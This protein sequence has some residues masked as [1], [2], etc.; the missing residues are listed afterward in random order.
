M[1]IDHPALFQRKP[2]NWGSMNLTPFP[3]L[4][5]LLHSS[6]IIW[7]GYMSSSHISSP[8]VAGPQNSNRISGKVNDIAK[9]VQGWEQ[10]E[11]FQ[12]QREL[13][14]TLEVIAL[15]PWDSPCPLSQGSKVL[16]SLYRENHG[17][18]MTHS[19]S[20]GLER[21]QDVQSPLRE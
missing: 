9:Q 15:S 14:E 13:S 21:N 6:W 20:S 19:R 12:G 17:N 16:S 7:V 11:V 4:K 1:G 5:G 3:F 18:Q 2:E 8:C 10:S